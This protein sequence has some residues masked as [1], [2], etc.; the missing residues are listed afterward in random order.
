MSENPMPEN[1]VTG[2]GTGIGDKAVR[3]A[4][5][6]SSGDWYALL[7]AAGC[8]HPAIAAWLGE[9]HGVPPWWRQMLT[10]GFEQARWALG[11][12]GSIL[13]AANPSRAGKTSVSLTHQ[14]LA[15]AA[16]VAP[17]Q[18]ALQRWLAAAGHEKP[19][20]LG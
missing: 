18:A 10:V 15:D 9:E 11:Q 3:S 6:R 14:R 13:A 1:P 17:A 2:T 4:T 19:M 7:G 8:K 16:A 20:R 5:G 12:A